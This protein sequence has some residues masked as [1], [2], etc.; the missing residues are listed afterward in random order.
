MA[1][2]K[3]I[4]ESEA[5]MPYSKA[6]KAQTRARNLAEA[7]HA[8]REEGIDSVGIPAL[9]GRAGLT[10]GGFYAHFP[11]KDALVAAACAEGF[12]EAEERLLRAAA[13]ADPENSLRSI[14]IGYLSRKHRDDPATGCMIPALSAE[15]ARAPHKTRAAFT[16]ALR[17]YARQFSAYFPERRSVTGA[18]QANTGEV[19]GAQPDAQAEQSDGAHDADLPAPGDAER[20]EAAREDDALVL[21]SGMAGA[22]LLARAVDDPDYSR[23][24]LRAARMFYLQAFADAAASPAAGEGTATP[25]AS[26]QMG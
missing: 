19:M 9:M 24:I 10:H 25:T 17:V 6:H 18:A 21:L 5:S 2:G 23:R 8:F 15:I 3:R 13:K 4:W 1:K 20:D 26:P 12:I 22:L 7:A 16:R 14:I 11:T